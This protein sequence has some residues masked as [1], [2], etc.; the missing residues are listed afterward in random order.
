MNS[1]QRTW[2]A[3][4]WVLASLGLMIG[5]VPGREHEAPKPA[6]ESEGSVVGIILK[7]DGRSK[8]EP[9]AFVGK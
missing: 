9:Q 8:S 5:R 6:A 4:S 7:S 1:S 2:R 3:W